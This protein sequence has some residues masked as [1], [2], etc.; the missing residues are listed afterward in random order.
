MLLVK[1]VALTP[2]E[3]IRQS[4][5]HATYPSVLH[6]NTPTSSSIIPQSLNMQFKFITLTALVSPPLRPRLP[7]P[8]PALT[9]GTAE[10]GN[11]P[12]AKFISLILGL[13]GVVVGDVTAIIGINCSPLSVIGIG[14]GACAANPVCCENNA[15]GGLISIGCLPIN[16]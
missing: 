7:L 8:S 15:V 11:A 14:G 1:G 12:P 13:L 16:L 2:V 3:K 5:R 4:I 6:S 10:T 9:A